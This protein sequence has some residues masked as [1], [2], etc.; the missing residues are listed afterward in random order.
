MLVALTREFGH[1]EE[2][3]AWVGSRAEVVEVALTTTTYRTRAEVEHEIRESR[4]FGRFASLVVTSARAHE[5]L[6][7]VGTALVG[8]PEVFSVGA[9]TSRALTR[10]G[11]DVT[12]ESPGAASEL[13]AFITHG[14]VLVLAARRGRSELIDELNARSLEPTLVECYETHAVELSDEACGQ[15]A[16][17]DVVFIGAPSAWRV[18]R[19]VVREDAWVLVPGTTTFEEVRAAHD[20]VLIGWGEEFALA[21]ARVMATTS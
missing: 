11:F 19:A 5:F 15:L 18:A 14:P 2:L 21:W 12:V 20:R 8:A 10:S 4:N 17:A 3:R 6:G 1:N 7:L 16:R 9:A 13:A